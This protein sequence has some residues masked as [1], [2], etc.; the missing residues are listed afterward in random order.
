MR[1]WWLRFVK[2]VVSRGDGKK[3]PLPS[4]AGRAVHESLVMY[5]WHQ[6]ANGDFAEMAV[7]EF[8]KLM[9]RARVG[10]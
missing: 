9:S 5:T 2:G 1:S 4:R 6:R 7:K 3:V 8:T 10:V